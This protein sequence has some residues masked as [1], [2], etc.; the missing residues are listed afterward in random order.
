VTVPAP[1]ACDG[2]TAHDPVSR[3]VLVKVSGFG[4]SFWRRGHAALLAAEESGRY[5]D[6]RD[7]VAHAPGRRE[8]GR[9]E[10]VDGGW[11]RFT[12]SDSDYRQLAGEGLSAIVTVDKEA[13]RILGVKFR[14]RSWPTRRSSWL[15][16]WRRLPVTAT[17]CLLWCI[18]LCGLPQP[19][20]SDRFH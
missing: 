4:A 10:P 11:L 8:I 1:L 17:G 16:L 13:G 15:R 7:V 5:W 3:S 20:L 6:A 14:N 9:G 18:A 12:L 19:V 2:E